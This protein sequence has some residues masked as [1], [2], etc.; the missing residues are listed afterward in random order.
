MWSDRY[1]YL[2]IYYDEDLSRDFDT[3]SLVAFIKSLPELKEK[4]PLM[5]GNVSEFPFTDIQ[6]LKAESLLHWS[7]RDRNNE[8]TNLITLIC[9]KDTASNFESHLTLLIKIASFVK[10]KL[11]DERTDDD[12][13]NYVLWAP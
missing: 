13:D 9:S 10:W 8:R 1:Y 5:F 6:L 3:L 7:E 11:V 12:I 2:N 4:E